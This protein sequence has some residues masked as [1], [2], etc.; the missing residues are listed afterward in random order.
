[1]K[2]K[3][4]KLRNNWTPIKKAC[5]RG[6]KRASFFVCFFLGTGIVKETLEKDVRFDE[7]KIENNRNHIGGG[8]IPV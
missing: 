6:A 1:M 8:C 7:K 5:K 4:L 2:R 3:E